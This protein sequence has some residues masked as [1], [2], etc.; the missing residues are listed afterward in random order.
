MEGITTCSVKL[1]KD[2]WTKHAVIRIEFNLP[3]DVIGLSYYSRMD[4][5]LRI[6]WLD[7]AKYP[8][9]WFVGESPLQLVRKLKVLRRAAGYGYSDVLNILERYL[10]DDTTVNVLRRTK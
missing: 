10:E 4:D 6:H 7:A 9:E 1:G 8:M 3:P 2:N 5:R